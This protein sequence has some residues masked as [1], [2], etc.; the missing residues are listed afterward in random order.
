MAIT[1]VT[2]YIERRHETNNSTPLKQLLIGVEW[3]QIE[4]VSTRLRNEFQFFPKSVSVGAHY[5]VILLFKLHRVKA[6]TGVESLVN[7][8][9]TINAILQYIAAEPA[10]G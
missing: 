1:K 9:K 2:N 5:Y 6:Y 4:E 3:L 8:V 7:W 10:L